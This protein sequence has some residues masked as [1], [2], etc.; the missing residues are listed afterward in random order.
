MGEG[1]GPIATEP[2]PIDLVPI[3]TGLEQ[4]VYGASTPEDPS[5]L[6]IVEKVGKV[7]LRKGGTLL[8]TPF[9]DVSAL[10]KVPTI[11][12]EQGLLSMA[13]APDYHESGRF[14]LLYSTPSNH[15]VLAELARD[16][17]NPDVASPTP[18]R[19]LIDIPAAAGHIAGSLAF[20][21]DG[22]LYLGLGDSNSAQDV[23]SKFG[24]V[25]RIDVDTYP[26]PPPGN[27][28]GVDADP[29]VWAMG[30]HNPWRFSFDREGGDF[31]L[32]DVG[33]NAFEEINRQSAADG[34]QNYGYPKQHGTTCATAPCDGLRL[35]IFVYDHEENGRC[36]V[37]GGYVYRGKR[38]AWLVGQYVFG[39]LCSGEILALELPAGMPAEL[40]TLTPTYIDPTALPEQP[41]G[42]I[43]DGDGELSVVDL[44]GSILR[45]EPRITE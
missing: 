41:V 30:F 6:Y 21:P 1:G 22:L 33:G 2:G 31:F 9:V 38:L 4:P 12:Q 8:D 35:P 24:K 36:A 13:L 25:L 14:F 29:D 43:E 45:L 32:G 19:K 27:V 18:V 37:M 40:H 7:K 28:T 10:I 16:P 42:F 44:K 39:D 26:T 3:A 34:P 23:T 15:I 5:R 11:G 20:G 17:Q